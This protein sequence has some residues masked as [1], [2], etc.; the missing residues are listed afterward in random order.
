MKTKR[1]ILSIAIVLLE[2]INSV[3]RFFA[4]LSYLTLERNMQAKQESVFSKMK[5]QNQDRNVKKIIYICYP[6][7]KCHTTRSL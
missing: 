2:K 4:L 3:I 7:F 1:N 5:Q 6:R